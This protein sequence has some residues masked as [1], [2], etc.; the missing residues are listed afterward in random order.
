M[1]RQRVARYAPTV[2]CRHESVIGPSWAPARVDQLTLSVR[3]GAILL[4]RL[5]RNATTLH[6]SRLQRCVRC[7][8][9]AHRPRRKAGGLREWLPT[10]ISAALKLRGTASHCSVAIFGGFHISIHDRVRRA[11][12]RFAHRRDR[13]RHGPGCAWG[14]SATLWES[15]GAAPPVSL[16]LVRR[17]AEGSSRV[18]N[19]T[20]SNAH[21]PPP[22]A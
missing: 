8:Y 3:D 7:S 15:P 1:R 18:V 17:W 6:E 14:G 16:P 19:T 2:H 12:R 13:W 10:A 20:C 11:Y 4:N 5:H 21:T 22:P 9:S